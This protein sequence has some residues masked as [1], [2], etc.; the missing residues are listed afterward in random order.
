MI[1][2]NGFGCALAIACATLFE[3]NTAYPFD[4]MRRCGN[5]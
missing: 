2:P 3:M 4:D 5:A 1:P